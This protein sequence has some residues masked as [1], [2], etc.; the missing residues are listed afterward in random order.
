MHLAFYTDLPELIIVSN[1]CLIFTIPEVLLH[2]HENYPFFIF[3]TQQMMKLVFDEEVQPEHIETFRKTLQRR[4]SPTTVFGTFAFCGKGVPRT[5]TF[6][7]EKHMERQGTLRKSKK[8]LANASR[9]KAGSIAQIRE[10][11]RKK[12]H[13]HNTSDPQSLDHRSPSGSLTTDDDESVVD[14]NDISLK[15]EPIVVHGAERLSKLSY[16]GDYSRLK[17][18]NIAKDSAD[19]P[20]RICMVNVTYTACRRWG[21]SLVC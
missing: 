13:R 18:G 17:L 8:K 16:C 12:R 2:L 4:R 15:S 1:I 10:S 6:V 7:I 11:L 9:N 3:F 14:V 19:G 21:W 20:W 5:P